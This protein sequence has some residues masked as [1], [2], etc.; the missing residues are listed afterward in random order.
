LK[1]PVLIAL[2]GVLAWGSIGAAEPA[3]IALVVPGRPGTPEEAAPTLARFSA[4]VA[5]GAGL[6]AGSLETVYEPD[7]DAGRALLEKGADYAVLPLS[8]LL[9]WEEELGG[10]TP[11]AQVRTERGSDERFA[12]VLP[13]GAEPGLAGLRI[14]GTACVEPEFVR[15]VVLAGHAGAAETR[16]VFVRRTLSAL[17]RLPGSEGEA[18][19][20]D[21]AQA[22]ALGSLPFAGE[23]QTVLTSDAWPA[24][25][26]VA[27]DRAARPASEHEALGRGLAT[28]HDSEPGRVLAADMLL[29]R[30]VEPDRERLA[31]ARKLFR[32]KTAGAGE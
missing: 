19:L 26:F 29:E 22:D 7:P 12:L 28:L 2:V 9:A 31:R 25:F 11:L 24:L 18:V 16:P 30:F 1:R 32:G 4:A 27:L 17:R 8:L 23:L 14:Q 10:L 15:R 20:L 13:R 6:P 3:L 5:E 21:E